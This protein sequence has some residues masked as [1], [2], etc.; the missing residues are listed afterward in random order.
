M[1]TIISGAVDQ[2]GN[3][4]LGTEYTSILAS[5]NPY[6]VEVTF[7][8]PFDALEPPIA[9]A[10]MGGSPSDPVQPTTFAIKVSNTGLIFTTGKLQAVPFYFIVTD[11]GLG[12]PPRRE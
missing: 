4:V 3:R 10:S 6:T 9:M 12:Y 1:A 7:N 8:Q 5:S 2:N 11:R